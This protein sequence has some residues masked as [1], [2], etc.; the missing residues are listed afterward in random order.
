MC[1]FAVAPCTAATLGRRAS[2]SRTPRRS[3]TVSTTASGPVARQRVGLA[4]TPRDGDGG[5]AG[6]PGRRAR[7]RWRHRRRRSRAGR[8]PARAAAC[9]SGSGRGLWRGGVLQAATTSTRWSMPTPARPSRAVSRR[10][11]VAPP[12]RTPAAVSVGEQLGH[13]V[14]W[15][16]QPVGVGEVPLAVDVGELGPCSGALLEQRRQQ[17]AGRSTSGP[18]RSSTS[19][20]TGCGRRAGRTRR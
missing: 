20:A 10:F 12:V 2:A 17:R 11:D 18:R 13:P 3:A 1:L 9:S 15:P 14:V 16:D 5:H 8:R 4:R 7:R 6:G 19:S